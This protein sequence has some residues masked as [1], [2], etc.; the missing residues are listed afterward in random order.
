M[1]KPL[2]NQKSP[3][4][5]V[6]EWVQGEATSL[7]QL[8]GNVVLVEV[9]QVNC[10]GCFLYSLPAA[11]AL[12]QQY[13]TQGLVVLGVATAFEDFNKNTLGN[14]KG[15]LEKGEVVGE[16]L[17]TLQQQGRLTN[18][19]LPYRIPFPVAMDR[20]TQRQ[21]EA[22]AEEIQAFITEKLPDFKDYPTSQQQ[23]VQ[24]QVEQYFAALIYHAETFDRFHLQGTPSHILIDKQ[25]KLRACK[26]GAYTALE[27]HILTLLNE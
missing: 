20:L 1:K 4:L 15:L 18:G 23:V 10:P 5:S 24:Q 8:L 11:V 21:G 16:T 25:G 27:A 3:S 19:S 7:E 13:S 17:H 9:F 14:L 22:S 6:S 12:H 26:F 2:F